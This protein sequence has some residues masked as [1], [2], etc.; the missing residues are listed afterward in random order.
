[1]QELKKEG[2]E[3]KTYVLKVSNHASAHRETLQQN[4]EEKIT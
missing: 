3:M 1:M 2:D 4:Y